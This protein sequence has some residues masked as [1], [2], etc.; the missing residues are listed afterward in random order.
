MKNIAKKRLPFCGVGTALVTP[1]DPLG[2]VDLA[3]FS[4]LCK[5]QIEGGVSALVVAGT[6]GEAIT[7]RKSERASL[8][9][10]ACESGDG[11]VPI[12]AGTGSA[13]TREAVAAARY[14]ATHGADALLVVTPYYNKGT[15]EGLVQHYLTIA[16]AVD[17]PI[18][19]YN[20]P[21][22]TGVNIPM[23]ALRALAEHENIVA[24]KEASGSIDRS[25]DIITEFGERLWLYSGN[26]GELLPTLSLGGVGVISVVSN[27]LPEEACELCA[28]YEAGKVKE[29]AILA[30]R[31]LPLIRLLFADTNPAPVKYAMRELG[32]LSG[33][34]RLPLTM[35][36]EALSR[37]IR[38]ALRALLD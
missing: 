17:I 26:D 4:R 6:T 7:L 8:L 11:K 29:A 30:G 32:L 9:S 27:L 33:G 34:V 31:L 2:R 14:A 13:D 10:A 16:E 1:F 24:I 28:L 19:L 37:R 36:D 15:R 38:D 18:I 23:E 20:V 12:I 35:P 21:S 22:R 25:A 5:R 3:T